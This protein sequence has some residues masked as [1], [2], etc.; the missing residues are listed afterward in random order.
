MGRAVL[1]T[2]TALDGGRT[3]PAPSAYL[4]LDGKVVPGWAISLFVL[5]LIVPVLLTTI[6][7]VARARRRRRPVWAWLAMVLA[8]AT[9]FALAA[10]VVKL[11]GAVGWISDAT[12]G[13]LPAGAVP[14]HGGGTITLILAACVA[15]GALAILRPF[16]AG[17]ASH[18]HASEGA[19][20]G[21]LIVLVAVTI[22]I[23]VYNPYAALLLVPALHLW[24]PA[25][26]PGS[27]LP[28]VARAALLAL[29]VVPVVAAGRLLRD[30]AGLRSA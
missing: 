10:A 30:H 19:V 1:S 2:I 28:L 7:G 22:A 16:V 23:W 21:L 29:G 13:P 17:L 15:L 12:P 6:D 4:L 8:A 3:I 11:A 14:L 26:N 25:L 18:D 9:P 20:P 24:L 5:A 27:R